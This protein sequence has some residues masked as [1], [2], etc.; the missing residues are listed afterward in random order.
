[1]NLILTGT[2]RSGTT[3]FADLLGKGT[4]YPNLY[5][6]NEG[7]PLIGIA[8]NVCVNNGVLVPKDHEIDKLIQY[9]W[10]QD[11]DTSNKIFDLAWSQISEIASGIILE[12]DEE[13]KNRNL[14]AKPIILGIK[15]TNLWK[16]LEGL[17]QSNNCF[18]VSARAPF[19]VYSSHKRRT[20]DRKPEIWKKILVDIYYSYR[21]ASEKN[22]YVIYFEKLTQN[23]ELQVKIF[24][25]DIG[26]HGKYYKTPTTIIQNSSFVDTGAVKKVGFTG[27]RTASY[28]ERIAHLTRVEFAML[29]LVNSVVWDGRYQDGKFDLC[30]IEDLNSEL[31]LLREIEAKYYDLST[32]F[33]FL[34]HD[35]LRFQ[36]AQS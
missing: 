30:A 19:E 4:N 33:Y 7:P 13:S 36:T 8:R 1:M 5:V 18:V 9:G 20:I 28:E 12:K 2:M 32:P 31:K 15:Y 22:A 16:L 34:L 3:L 6:Q 26:L 27:E 21:F 10:T 17:D 11:C 35:E 24:L 29:Q 25:D 14:D 23:K